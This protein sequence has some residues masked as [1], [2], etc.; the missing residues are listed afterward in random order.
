MN[1]TV[2]VLYA[3]GDPVAF[4]AAAFQARKQTIEKP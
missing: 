4:E 3:D 1:D 2:D